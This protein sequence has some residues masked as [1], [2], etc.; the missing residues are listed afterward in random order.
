MVIFEITDATGA[1]HVG[2]VQGSGGPLGGGAAH[3]G[4]VG[5]RAAAE[6]QLK[7][8]IAHVNIHGSMPPGVASSKPGCCMVW[9]RDDSEMTHAELTAAIVDVPLSGASY[10]VLN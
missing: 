7:R 4:H 10:R 8:L 5:E 1:V 6:R 9:P 2:S 3:L